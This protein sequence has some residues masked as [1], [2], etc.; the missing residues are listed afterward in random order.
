MSGVSEWLLGVPRTPAPYVEGALTTALATAVGVFIDRHIVLPNISLVFVVPV[1]I[2]AARHGLVPSLWV[3]A[4]S[5]LS[6]NFFFLPP[7]FKF[8][9]HDPDNVLG[10][11]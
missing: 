6:Y 7:L 3:A 10:L 5:M 2:A 1:L 9:I 4:L 11:L 8:T